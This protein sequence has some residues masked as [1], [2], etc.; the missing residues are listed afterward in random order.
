MAQLIQY[1]DNP[2]YY[3]R[4]AFLKDGRLHYVTYQTTA[5]AVAFLASRGVA[6][7]DQIASPL[8]QELI[9]KKLIYTGGSGAGSAEAGQGHSI[10]V[11]ERF[12]RLSASSRRWVTARVLCHP[13]VRIDRYAEPTSDGEG[14]I[15]FSSIPDLYVENLVGLADR[16]D[17]TSFLDE[18]DSSYSSTMWHDILKQKKSP[19]KR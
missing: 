1:S 13:N 11:S 14:E 2:G 7:G 10:D 8:V 9:R 3:I 18:L 17:G 5:E 4:H 6:D 12:A 16:F 19:K 15:G